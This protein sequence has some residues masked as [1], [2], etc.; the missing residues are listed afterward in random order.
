MKKRTTEEWLQQLQ[1]KGAEQ[2]PALADLRAHLLH[3]ALYALNRYRS[4]TRGR[5]FDDI[6]ALAEDCAQNALVAVLAHLNDFRHD[7]EFTTW[8]YKFAVNTAL[9]VQRRQQW[10]DVS[11]DRLVAEADL[12]NVL[13][14]AA[15][16]HDPDRLATYRE[17]WLTIRSVI[18]H[19][20]TERQRFVMIAIVFQSVPLDVISER[21]GVD[22]NAIYKLLHDARRKL[23]Q[24]LV[25]RGFAPS[26][27]MA[28]FSRD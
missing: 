15:P 20:L 19:D 5:S 18:E 1:A 3:A 11:L 25:Q 8:A 13:L 28:D 16:Q 4:E 14:D 26:E 6:S 17:L 24:S 2:E 21:L 10:K 12:E 22:R 23:K 9:V 27:I 7:S